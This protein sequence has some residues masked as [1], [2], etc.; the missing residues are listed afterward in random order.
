LSGSGAPFRGVGVAKSEDRVVKSASDATLRGSVVTKSACAVAKSES[1]AA[2]CGTCAPFL[3]I[4]AAFSG[5]G[6]DSEL[7]EGAEHAAGVFLREGVGQ[8]GDAVLVALAGVDEDFPPREFDVLDAQAQTLQQAHAG[9]IQQAG[10]QAGGAI[11][12]QQKFAHLALGQ[13]HG[14]TARHFGG[15]VALAGEVAEEGFDFGGTHVARVARMTGWRAVF[16]LPNAGGRGYCVGPD[17][18]VALGRGACHRPS[19]GS[20]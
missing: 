1:V 20:F 18:D 2:L 10:D 12:L 7:V 17:G 3:G 11:Q 15:H 8:H 19:G 5:N 13:Y 4:G 9:A 16:R 14:Q 6:V